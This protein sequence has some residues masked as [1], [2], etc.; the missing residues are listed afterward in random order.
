MDNYTE[1]LNLVSVI[2]PSYNCEAYVLDAIDSVMKQT[3]RPL[4]II[5]IDDGSMDNTQKVIHESFFPSGD[6]INKQNL[7]IQYF[8]QS[9]QGP[10]AARN[11]G[12]KE[13]RGK[14]IAFLDAD[15]L[16]VKNKLERSICFLKES[17]FDWIC[18]SMLKIK[19]SGEKFVKGIPN[20]SFV[21]DPR[22]KEIKQLTKGIFFFSSIAVHTPTIVV[23]KECFDKVGLFDESFCICEDTDLW[24]RF[25]EAGLKGGYLD[26]PLTIYSYNKNSLTKG[27]RV[28]TLEESSK[29][30]RKHAHILGINNK[31]IRTSYADY[32]WQVADIYFTN[33]NYFKTVKYIL[34]SLYYNPQNVIRGIRKLNGHQNPILWKK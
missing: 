18:T 9:N 26:E 33:K 30:A 16:W 24:L 6:T 2:I 1:T 34:M 29:V 3:H 7:N 12:I 15:D 10:A 14:Y 19:E 25:E 5:V 32:L 22:T 13:A 21:L 31:F 4:E 17:N 28:D 23:K 11:R 27:G 8:Y 20:G